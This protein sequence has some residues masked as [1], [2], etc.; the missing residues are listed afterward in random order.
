[1]HNAFLIYMFSYEVS[2]LFYVVACITHSHANTS[3]NKHTD[4]IPTIAKSNTV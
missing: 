4:I 1:M 3:C 2:C